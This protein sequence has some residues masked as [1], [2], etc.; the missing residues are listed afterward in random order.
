MQAIRELSSAYSLVISSGGIGPTHDDI[1][2]ESIAEAMNR[3]LIYHEPTLQLM[4]QAMYRKNT[5]DLNEGQ[6]R[7]ALIPRPDQVLV[8]PGLWVPLVRVSNILI[9]PGVPR[10]FQQMIDNWLTCELP[11]DKSLV[12][13]RMIR[14]LIKTRWWESQVASPLKNIQDEVASE[15]IQ[16]GSYP[17]MQEDGTSYVILSLVGPAEV[18]ERIDQVA[19]ELEC[20][21]EGE[22]IAL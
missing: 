17:K 7:M 15:G 4:K 8:T 12:C 3:P 22:Q 20:V 16:V 2:Y 21:F 9:L 19:R 1:T 5:G 6:R 18:T 10:L 14:R 13:Q 11:K